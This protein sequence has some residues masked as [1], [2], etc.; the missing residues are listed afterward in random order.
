MSNG[1]PPQLPDPA[2]SIVRPPKERAVSALLKFL[3]LPGPR[4]NRA[5]IEAHL[6]TSA[7][8]TQGQVDRNLVKMYNESVALGAINVR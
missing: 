5:A 3:V 7:K 4:P 6:R 1:T 2:T 8:L